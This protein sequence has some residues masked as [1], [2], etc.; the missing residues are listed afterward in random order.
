MR[1]RPIECEFSQSERPFERGS[2]RHLL[3][4]YVESAGAE[5][6]A[7]FEALV[8][9]HGPMV[10]KVCRHVLRGGNEVDDAFQATFFI[11]ARKAGSLKNPQL[12]GNWLYGVASKV[13]ARAREVAVRRNA[14]ERLGVVTHVIAAPPLDDVDELRPVIHEEVRRLPEKFR[15]PI[16]LCY[17]EGRTHEEAA[18]RLSCPVG[19]VK[20]RLSRARDLLRERLSRRGLAITTMFLCLLIGYDEAL[21]EV[22]ESLVRSTVRKAITI[23]PR[24]SGIR[25]PFDLRVVVLCGIIALLTGTIAIDAVLAF[26]DVSTTETVHQVLRRFNIFAW[27]AGFF[28]EDAADCPVAVAERASRSAT[29]G[30]KTTPSSVAIT[31]SA[32]ISSDRSRSFGRSSETVRSTKSDPLR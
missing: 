32:K 4:L 12:L 9:R 17:F 7:A 6:E 22:D 16:V 2:D 10:L 29:I 14:R 19:T 24:R 20:G 15:A 1:D 13:S 25:F 18:E 3:R 27:M 11:L 23:R 30:S 31:K 21:A 5:R 8:R 28:E 26:G